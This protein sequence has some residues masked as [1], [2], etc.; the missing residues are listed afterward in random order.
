LYFVAIAGC[1]GSAGRIGGAN[2][3]GNIAGTASVPR[4]VRFD[5]T[6]S[7]AVVGA[8]VETV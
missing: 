3:T 1:A 2:S 8:A 4:K 5:L 6:C 7:T